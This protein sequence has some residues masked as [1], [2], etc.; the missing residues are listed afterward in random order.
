MYNDFVLIGPSLD[1]AKVKL[2][3]NVVEAFQ[4]IAK[5]QILFA[6]RGG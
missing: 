2:Q 5:K 1:P 3:N 4:A 6:S